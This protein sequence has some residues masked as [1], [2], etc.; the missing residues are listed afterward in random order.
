MLLFSWSAD[1]ADYS[2][3]AVPRLLRNV[4][5]E[6]KSGGIVLMHDGGGNRSHT[7]QALP[8]VISRFREQ[9]Y[10]FVTIPELLELQDKQQKPTAKKKVVET[11]K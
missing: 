9:G 2:R 8:E 4:F 6:A 3:P 1:S 7:V 11:K 5:R 10:R